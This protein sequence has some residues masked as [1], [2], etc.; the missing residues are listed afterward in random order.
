MSSGSD[1]VGS[2]GPFTPE[3][4]EDM[5]AA[6]APEHLQGCA[7]CRGLYKLL[8]HAYSPDR[9]ASYDA[10]AGQELLCDRCGVTSCSLYGCA[11]KDVLC[12]HGR[13]H[14]RAEQDRVA[15]HG[16]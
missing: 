10:D 11:C 15:A 5:A 12:P 7:R 16:T 13:T 9:G 3:Q 6:M 2:F 4:C 1:D 14:L 8:V